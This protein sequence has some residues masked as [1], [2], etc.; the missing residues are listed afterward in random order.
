[1]SSDPA[2]G[3][4][5]SGSDWNNPANAER[6]L[7][8]MLDNISG[9]FAYPPNPRAEPRHMSEA[10]RVER[11]AG[12]LARTLRPSVFAANPDPAGAFRATIV[13]D[14]TASDRAIA[15]VVGASVARRD[16]VGRVLTRAEP[17]W[18]GLRVRYMY[19]AHSGWGP[20][21]TGEY[22]RAPVE[23]AG[24]TMSVIEDA[25]HFVSTRS[26]TPACFLLRQRTYGSCIGRTRT[27]F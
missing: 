14:A 4:P 25:N 19:M 27:A 8:I 26:F 3:N 2:V 18:A 7:M 16:A 5:A 15:G 24:H 11:Y 1:M 10:E 20:V 6:V 17:P 12:A 22:M 13:T 23:A 9:F 21:Y